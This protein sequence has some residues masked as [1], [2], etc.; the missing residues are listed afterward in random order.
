M[1]PH[2]FGYSEGREDLDRMGGKG[3]FP[4]TTSS[5][6]ENFPDTLNC[7]EVEIISQR[8]CEDA[9]P[10]KITEG[11][12]CAGNSNGADTCQV[13]DFQ[14]SSLFFFFFFFCCRGFNTGPTP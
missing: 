2:N 12:V 1:V 4:L 14:G 6:S 11:M 3:L 8:K 9:Y 13:S 10:G 7:A 5:P